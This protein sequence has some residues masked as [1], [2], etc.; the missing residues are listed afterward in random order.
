MKIRKQTIIGV[1]LAS[2]IVSPLGVKNSAMASSEDRYTKDTEKIS[3][4]DKGTLT[5]YCENQ[6]YGKLTGKSRKIKFYTY[7]AYNGSSKVEEIRVSWNLGAKMRNKCELT[8]TVSMNSN[9]EY[10]VKASA[11]M[12]WQ[13]CN[14]AKKYW[15]STNGCRTEYEDSNYVI[16]PDVDL[17][18]YQFWLKSTAYVKLKGYSHSTSISTGT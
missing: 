12:S 17:K 5:S 10:G 9:R 6:T 3:C 13:N 4:P 14:T 8:A 2:I 18:G 11:S 16:A 1:L 15:S 7:A